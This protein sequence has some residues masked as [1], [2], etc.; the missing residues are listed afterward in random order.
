MV[1]AHPGPIDNPEKYAVSY[2]NHRVRFEESIPL[3]FLFL[4]RSLNE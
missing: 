3:G 4:R 2:N 1:R